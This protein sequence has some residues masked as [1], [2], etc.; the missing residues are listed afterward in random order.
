MKCSHDTVRGENGRLVCIACDAPIGQ[1]A[2]KY[3]AE[4][5]RG[6]ASKKEAGVAANLH[7]LAKAG[8]ICNLEEQVRFVLVPACGGNSAV[9]YVCDFSYV[10]DGKLHI[11]DA[12]GCI[13]PIYRIKK[14][15]MYFIHG[16]SVEEV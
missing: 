10:E 7:A 15:L 4:R 8:N 1:K 5:H 3:G 13:T 2:N 11:V 14:A 12:K 16:I 9:S 6:Y